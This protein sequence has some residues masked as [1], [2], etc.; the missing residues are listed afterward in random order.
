MTPENVD[1]A[2][3]VPSVPAQIAPPS[4]P[5]ALSLNVHALARTE[6][7]AEMAPPA[8]LAVV[9]TKLLL[10]ASAVLVAKMA[11]PCR[12]TRGDTAWTCQG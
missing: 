7:E 9:L 5:A 1:S 3:V 4:W 11:P 10:R 8:S 2:M 6:P 12:A